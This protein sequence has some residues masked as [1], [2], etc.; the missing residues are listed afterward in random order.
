VGIFLGWTI[1][2]LYFSPLEL[3]LFSRGP[4][5]VFLPLLARSNS[6]NPISSTT[7]PILPTMDPSSIVLPTSSPSSH[8]SVES[9]SSVQNNELPSKKKNFF[10][11]PADAS[12]QKA[13]LKPSATTSSNK[14]Q[15]QQLSPNTDDERTWG[16]AV[17]NALHPLSLGLLMV[18]QIVSLNSVLFG[19]CQNQ[20]LGI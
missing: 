7:A 5:S 18:R 13:D 10:D 19:V 12:S 8:Q 20:L 14:Q 15:P 17:I 6:E 16:E 3:D 9:S 4:F 1:V 11:D 2:S